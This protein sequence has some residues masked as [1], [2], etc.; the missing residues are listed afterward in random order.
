VKELLDKDSNG[1]GVSDWE[2]KL[3]GLDPKVEYTGGVANKTIIEQRKQSLN[4]PTNNKISGG[5]IN[6]TEKLSRELFALAAT[7][8]QSDEVDNQTLQEIASK[9]GETVRAKT[10]VVYTVK[11]I[12]TVPTTEE[13]LKKYAKDI[14]S[15]I[16]SFDKNTADIDLVIKGLENGDFSHLDELGKSAVIYKDYSKKL[17]TVTAP[18][19]VTQYHLSLLNSFNGFAESFYYLS[20]IEDDSMSGLIGVAIY[21]AYNEKI[22]IATFNLE[23]YLTKYGII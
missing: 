10:S 5:A 22:A 2:E 7:L 21:Q 23:D 16:G 12:K 6:D 9:L 13:S 18:I 8:G 1:N 15:A 17:L 11:D 14:V 20:K 4:I 19:G 3:W